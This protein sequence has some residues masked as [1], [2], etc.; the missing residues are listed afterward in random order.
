M[1]DLQTLTI[2]KA[3]E[4]L[5]KGEYTAVDLAKAYLDVATKKNPDT[6]AYL[7][8][9]ADVLEQAKNADALIKAGKATL[10]TGI[11]LSI[12]DNILI[13]GR[14]VTAASKI[15]KGYIAPYDATAVA[16][17]KEQGVVF[18]GRTN[19]DEFAMGGS[20]ENSAFGPVKNPHD[21]TRVSGGS[22]GGAAA[23]VAMSGALA[24]LGSD[25]GGS[26]RQP[27]SFC[28][29][30]GF[31]PTYGAISR[32]GLM[33]MGSSLDQIGTLGKTVEDTKILFDA[34]K[35]NDIMDGTTLP[36]GSLDKAHT[37]KHYTIGVP[38]HFMKQGIDKDVLEN[39]ESSLEK[40]KKAGHTIK[41][42]T[43]PH[44][45]YSLAV[46]YVI[47]PAEVSSNL[48][49]FDG[50]KYGA[51]KEGDTLLQDYLKTRTEG[52]G[53]EARRRIMLGNYILSAGYYDAYYNKAQTVRELLKQDFE[54]AFKD[55]DFILTPTSPI[56][57]FKIGEKSS[58]PLQMYLADIF[59][60]IANLVSV[61]A[62]SVPSGFADREGK[63]LPLGIQFMAPQ[64]CDDTLFDIGAQFENVK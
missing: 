40:L 2:R 8:I 3:H 28:G 52:F 17:L 15:L 14:S 24:G 42:V 60:V 38:R 62:I 41:E 29:I 33:A 11:P 35:G 18:I 58:D 53:K 22:S 37:K 44:I 55:V 16:K 34:M 4:A 61:P 48:S 30:V 59:T 13:K 12:K 23:S 36:A 43:L 64:E 26:V 9:Y 63:K 6:N 51:L 56:P 57:A 39:F 27:A 49:R 45:D 31:K 5:K 32:Y 46:Y 7:E 20:N 54:T 25:T 10:L 1:I 19:M 21:L 50:V 47:M